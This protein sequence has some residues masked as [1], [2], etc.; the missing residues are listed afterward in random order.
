[1]AE[2]KSGWV[3]G[4]RKR[5]SWPNPLTVSQAGDSANE[6]SPNRTHRADVSGGAAASP[7]ANTSSSAP[8]PPLSLEQTSGVGQGGRD[9]HPPPERP[10]WAV[11]LGNTDASPPPGCRHPA[12]VGTS[13]CLIEGRTAA[14]QEAHAS[15][16]PGQGQG[17]VG[18]SVSLEAPAGEQ[19]S[20]C[21]WPVSH[22]ED[23]QTGQARQAAHKARDRP[24]CQ[25][26][27]PSQCPKQ[28][29]AGGAVTWGA[30]FQGPLLGTSPVPRHTSPEAKLPGKL[31]ESAWDGHGC[32]ILKPPQAQAL[33]ME[34]GS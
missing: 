2:V 10:P 15:H 25:D 7:R 28:D 30:S 14:V 16:L 18:W 3:G 5:T 33:N 1:M 9:Q 31:G 22:S 8:S 34:G 21:T 6:K 24:G 29:R 13:S 12:S 32:H 20:L 17:R 19:G 23:R 11:E 27:G 4:R 26:P